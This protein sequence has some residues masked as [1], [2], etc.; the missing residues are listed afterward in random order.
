MDKCPLFVIVMEF[1]EKL[2]YLKVHTRL[3]MGKDLNFTDKTVFHSS[4]Y[5][6]V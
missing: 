4:I 2:A 1:S 3:K 5:E 6:Y